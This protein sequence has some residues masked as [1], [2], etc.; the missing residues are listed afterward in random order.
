MALKIISVVETRPALFK[1]DAILEAIGEANR[2]AGYGHIE[3]FLVHTGQANGV[4]SR[5]VY[6]NDIDLPKPD[7]FLGVSSAVDAP[8]KAAIIAERFPDVLLQECPDLVMVIGDSECS[9][10]C[11]LATKGFGYRGAVGQRL[12]PALVHLEAGRRSLNCAVPREVNGIVIDM[13]ADYLFT[14]QESVN[15]NLLREGIAPE[16]MYFVGSLNVDTLLRH[17]ARAMKSRILNDLQLIRGSEIKPFA[18]LTLQQLSGAGGVVKLNC[19]QRTFSEIA[20]RLPLIFPASPAAVQCIH[21]AHLDD[22]FV[23]HALEGPEPWDARV[24]IRLIPLLGY[25]DFVRLMAA[26][27]VVLTDSPGIQEETEVLGVPSIALPNYDTGWA[28]AEEKANALTATDI[29][30]AFDRGLA[31]KVSRSGPTQWEE[32][33][34]RRVV[35]TL[36]RDFAPCESSARRSGITPLPG[37]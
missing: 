24:R 13:L 15:L 29:L 32:R 25:L 5:D 18:L 26:A 7:L 33:A 37:G 16:K 23:D 21:E 36:L 4:R 34:G 3:H 35:K 14:S 12:T 6:F 9:L 11:S 30:E 20:Q 28:M 27:K 19:L 2:F 10:E 31:G 1:L 22:F 8:D 17:C